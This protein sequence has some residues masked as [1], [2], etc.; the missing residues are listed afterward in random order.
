MAVD[1]HTH[2]RESD[3]S[4]QPADLVRKAAEAGLSALALTDHDTLSGVAEAQAA[5]E[6]HGIRLIPGTE[7]SLEWE[8]G[9]L[10]LVVLWLPD[11]PG[12]LQDEL[13][14]LQDSRA[15]RNERMV[16][17]LQDLGYAISHDELLAE[18]GSG[19]V[20][21]PHFAAILVRRGYFA[22][23]SSVFDELLGSGRPGYIGRE[24]LHPQQALALARASGAVSVLAHPHTLGHDR[25]EDFASTFEMLSGY[26]LHGV[27][28]Y[29]P[30]YDPV[31]RDAFAAQARTFGL[32]PGGGSDYHG[33]YK[34]GLELGTGRF[35]NLH[36]PDHVLDDLESARS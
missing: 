9:G 7:L 1:L 3:G 20:G 36:I 21:R 22:D 10:H 4:D 27:E 2:S 29:Y 25:S 19:V 11:E 5:A 31:Q 8:L 34:T 16:Q 35:N 6:L 12:P 23:P 14:R 28:C 18:A 30:E 24:R 33:S 13:R 32:I 26:G 15:G 17:R